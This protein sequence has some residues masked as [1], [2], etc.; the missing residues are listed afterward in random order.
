MR[1]TSLWAAN[2]ARCFNVPYTT[3]LWLR[4]HPE[5]IG[6][7]WSHSRN[8]LPPA[9]TPSTEWHIHLNTYGIN[10]DQP[11]ELL[12]KYQD[13]ITSEHPHR[14]CVIV[15]GTACPMTIWWPH[16]EQA[17]TCCKAI[18]GYG[19]TPFLSQSALHRTSLY[20]MQTI[21]CPCQ[22]THRPV[23][24]RSSARDLTGC[25]IRSYDP[26]P[27]TMA[28]LCLVIK[29]VWD[30]MPQARIIPLSPFMP[31]K[32]AVVHEAHGLSHGLSHTHYWPSCT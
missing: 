6:T 7:T 4:H 14:P 12:Q 8:G 23:P 26:P 3:I 2:G 25:Q 9:T 19:A 20:Q 5:E 24:H 27:E 1:E 10:G 11:Q 15:S 29:G 28:Q 13:V 30:Y 16:H 22:R 21:H 17:A 18:L 31:R 32:C